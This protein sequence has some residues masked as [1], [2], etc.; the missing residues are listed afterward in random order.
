[1]KRWFLRAEEFFF[2]RTSPYPVAACRI[3]VGAI[4]FFCYLLYWPD[5][6]TLFGDQGIHSYVLWSSWQSPLGFMPVSMLATVLMIA[7]ACFSVG[8]MT[9]TSGVVLFVCHWHFTRIGYLHTWGWWQVSGAFLV[10]LIVA[11]SGARASV[12]ARLRK[13]RGQ[14]ELR[15]IPMWPVRMLQV[16][17]ACVYLTAAYTRL[18]HHGWY[19]GAMLFEALVNVIFGRFPEVDWYAFKPVLYFFNYA[20]WALELAAP[21]LLWVPRTRTLTACGLI[22]LHIVLE[23]TTTVGWW[24]VLMMTML[25]LFLPTSWIER[26]FEAV[27]RKVSRVS[28]AWQRQDRGNA[29]AAPTQ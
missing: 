22:A 9:R 29:L 11:Q 27:G 18:Y 20:S 17:V 15:D 21:L 4:F 8:F 1:M 14:E 10:W 16:H 2:T 12:D 25:V 6:E 3:G 19:E 23:A 26:A 7:A 28:L 13:R 5:L 24:Q